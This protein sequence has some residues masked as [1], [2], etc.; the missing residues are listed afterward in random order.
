MNIKHSIGRPRVGV[1][2]LLSLLTVSSCGGDLSP[3][4]G[5]APEPGGYDPHLLVEGSTGTAIVNVA[6]L[7]PQKVKYVVRNGL[8]IH[9]GDIVV[10]PEELSGL[11]DPRTTSA[12]RR[13]EN[14][15]WP[16]A[17]MPVQIDPTIP[18]NDAMRTAISCALSAWSSQT[19]MTFPT[20]ISGVNEDFVFF[21]KGG[22]GFGGGLSSSVGRIAGS[23]KHTITLQATGILCS[24]VSHE[25]GHLLGL[26]HEQQRVD[27]NLFLKVYDGTEPGL[28]DRVLDGHEAEYT[29]Y[30]APHPAQ[31]G[32]D[33]VDNPAPLDFASIMLYDP[34]AGGSCGSLPCMTKL[35]NTTWIPSQTV[36]AQDADGIN[37]IYLKFSVADSSLGTT[38]GFR[39]MAV[40]SWAGNRLDLLAIRQSD[41][42]LMHASNNGSGWS[43]FNQDFGGNATTTNGALSAVSWGVNRIDW[44]SIRS[45][46]S[47]VT[48][49]FFDN[50]TIGWESLGGAVSGVA[51]ASQGFNKLSVFGIGTDGNIYLNSWNNGWSGWGG[52][53]GTGGY[54]GAIDAVSWGPGRLDVAAVST[55][56]QLK[57]LWSNGA[58]FGAE[59]M[60]DTIPSVCQGAVTISS[61][62]VGRLDIIYCSNSGGVNSA[63][64]LS[65]EGSASSGSWGKSMNVLSPFIGIV[66]DS[67]G[68]ISGKE[69]II[70]Y[71]YATTSGGGVWQRSK[72]RR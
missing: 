31:S 56:N 4:T 37:R 33:G 20:H 25:V 40:T 26:Y 32:G 70:D 42:H 29:R 17:A 57:H 41:S 38:A 30:T 11:A 2:S 16:G 1:V 61:W 45:D 65:F 23:G 64:R 51:I 44:V 5:P 49:G 63:K 7:P 3:S 6:D 21:Q 58:G 14:F 72:A 59:T 28:P 36:S 69:S 71:I 50:G 67:V 8:P 43:G 47:A 55:S 46:N 53:T 48:H 27:R 24:T 9:S 18:S 13:F 54:S 34:R 10:S 12:G 39:N 68:R 22:A 52:I 15:K 35:D 19:V 60:A 62:G 66:S